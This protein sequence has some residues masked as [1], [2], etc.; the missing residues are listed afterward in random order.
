MSAAEPHLEEPLRSL[1]SVRTRILVSVLLMAALGMLVAGTTSYVIEINRLDEVTSSNLRQE[2]QEFRTLADKGVDPSTGEPFA[3]V[4]DLLVTALQRN[5]ADENETFL[6]LV[7]GRPEYLPQG[8]RPFRLEDNGEVLAQLAAL[9]PDSDVV[10]RDAETSAGTVRFAAIQVRIDG[11]PTVG[12]Y[13]IARGVDLE[14]RELI[15]TIQTYAVVAAGS[16]VLIGVVGWLVAGRLL[17]PLR[18]LRGAARRISETDLTQRIPVTGNDDVSD[19]AHTFNAMLD[20]LQSAFGT[21]RQ[22][23]DDAGHELR[24]PI[25]IL[26]GHLELM[27][28]TDAQE[29]AETRA[30]VLD[31]RDR[32]SRLVEDLILLAKA[33]R[34]DFVSDA[35][36]HLGELVEDVLEKARA[37]GERRW[38]AEG[39]ADVTV[40][41]DGQRLTQALLQ[42]A[43]NAVKFTGRGDVVAVG[44]AVSEGAARLWVRDEGPGVPDEDKERIFERFGRAE[45]G[46]GVEGSG[47][48]LAIVS[49]IAEGHGGRVELDQPMGTG[50][51]FTLVIPLRSLSDSEP[52]D[53]TGPTGLPADRL[54]RRP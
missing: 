46:R 47:L 54:A 1:T 49:A 32:M 16:L 29:V 52:E 53:V 40:L 9:A 36:V 24:T 22:F 45:A 51:R 41:G 17:R 13:V 33:R 26:R 21:Q 28:S 4:E 18:L 20:R 34:P 38:T 30:L 50:A 39:Q 44:S 8:E 23:L 35:P 27:D 10:V 19:L 14:A 3:T 43:H 31:E 11:E 12:T 48:G 42:L 7:D 5:V 25:T 37:L 2:I 15:D 6:G